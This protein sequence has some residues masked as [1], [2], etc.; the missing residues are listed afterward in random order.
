MNRYETLIRHLF[1][2]VQMNR[3]F[4][5]GKTFVDC[6]PKYAAEEISKKYLE[7]KRTARV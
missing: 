5:D 1:E 4:P 2:D 3:I 7:A 6:I